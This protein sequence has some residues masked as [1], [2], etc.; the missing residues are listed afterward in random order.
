[1]VNTKHSGFQ[2]CDNHTVVYLLQDVWGTTPPAPG[3]K[4]TELKYVD[5]DHDEAADKEPMRS[6]HAA[7]AAVAHT[8]YHEIDF[9]KTDALKSVK[10]N[11]DVERNKEKNHT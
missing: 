5:L 6:P 3:N 9:V 11:I 2:N 7:T 10:E 1:M 8:E 4:D